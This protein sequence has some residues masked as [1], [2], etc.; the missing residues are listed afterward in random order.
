MG[1][2]SADHLAVGRVDARDQVRPVVVERVE[3]R[4]VPE[5]QGVEEPDPDRADE[6]GQEA[7]REQQLKETFQSAND[8][9]GG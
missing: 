5:D 7:E 8:P 3:L 2:I 1:T 9:R 4:E 6:D